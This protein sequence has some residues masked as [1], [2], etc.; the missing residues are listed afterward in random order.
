MIEEERP[1]YEQWLG[2]PAKI[3]E[4]VARHFTLE[5]RSLGWGKLRCIARRSN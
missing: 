3:P 2:Q 1:T 5:R 4:L